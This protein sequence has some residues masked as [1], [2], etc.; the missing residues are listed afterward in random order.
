MHQFKKLV[1]EIIKHVQ[2][3]FTIELLII[4]LSS[5]LVH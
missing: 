5:D 4:I 3:Y 1:A 2:I